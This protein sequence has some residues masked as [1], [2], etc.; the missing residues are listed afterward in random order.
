MISKKKILA[1]LLSCL[2][3]ILTGCSSGY[4]K[5]A[6][7]QENDLS[8]F[9]GQKYNDLKDFLYKERNEDENIYYADL[10]GETILGNT[11]I[12]VDSGSNGIINYI[13][14]TDVRVTPKQCNYNINGIAL[15]MDSNEAIEIFNKFVMDPKIDSDVTN[16]KY[17]E[18]IEYS[19]EY[20]NKELALYI[21]KD[22]NSVSEVTLSLKNSSEEINNNS[23]NSSTDD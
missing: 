10:S 13:S 17:E 16:S 7:S 19:G 9:V 4:N 20:D 3:I 12:I 1:V 22:R 14:L 23:S 11:G 21:S 15:G 5:E 8:R 2:L 18:L 6:L